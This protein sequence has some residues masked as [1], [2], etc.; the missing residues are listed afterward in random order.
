MSMRRRGYPSERRVKAGVQIVHG[1]KRLEEKLGRPVRSGP[2]RQTLPSEAFWQL[3]KALRILPVA[4]L[5]AAIHRP[6]AVLNL[7]FSTDRSVDW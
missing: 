6:N 2:V 1:D 5:L 3:R 7:A 4:P